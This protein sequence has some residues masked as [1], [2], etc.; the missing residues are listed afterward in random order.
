MGRRSLNAADSITDARPCFHGRRIECA[1]LEL[2]I[3][4]LG[5]S[6]T[7]DLEE[8]LSGILVTVKRGGAANLAGAI[9]LHRSK[10]D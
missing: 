8:M 6:E 10:P 1:Y 7:L 2:M 5:R 9:E 3:M 4:R